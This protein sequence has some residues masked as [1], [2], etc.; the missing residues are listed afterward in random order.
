MLVRLITN[1]LLIFLLSFISSYADPIDDFET[2][3]AAFIA[4]MYNS[5]GAYFPVPHMNEQVDLEEAEE[6]LGALGLLCVSGLFC[7]NFVPFL[8]MFL[9]F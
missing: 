3:E 7:E 6:D 1:F 4:A 8:I 5:Y 2:D 9:S